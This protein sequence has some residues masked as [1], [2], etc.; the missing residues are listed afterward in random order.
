MFTA[1]STP[2]GY[3]DHCSR[4]LMSRALCLFHCFSLLLFRCPQ[5]LTAISDNLCLQHSFCYER[6]YLEKYRLSI[7]VVRAKTCDYKMIYEKSP[8]QICRIAISQF[9][10]NYDANNDV[11]C[12]L[13]VYKSS[14]TAFGEF[15]KYRFLGDT[16][17]FNT[18]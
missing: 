15:Q 14:I 9:Y 16:S 6:S 1:E 12:K 13:V 5:R 7:I 11:F 17:G 18:G 10:S 8:L 2:V 4:V 3:V